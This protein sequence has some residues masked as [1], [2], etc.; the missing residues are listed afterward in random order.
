MKKEGWNSNFQPPANIPTELEDCMG[1]EE[2]NSIDQAL[3]DVL[4]D[5]AKYSY[6]KGIIGKKEMNILVNVGAKEYIF[7]P[8][9]TIKS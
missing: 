7:K 9:K 6:E 4:I 2:I 1:D 8:L 3:L 5:F